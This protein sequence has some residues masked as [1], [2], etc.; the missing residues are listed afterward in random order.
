[1]RRGILAA[2]LFGQL[3]IVAAV[4][5]GATLGAIGCLSSNSS[6]PGPGPTPNLD[7]GGTTLPPPVSDAS[8]S[9]TPTPDAAQPVNDDAG[10]PSDDAGPP[11]F[12]AGPP[13]ATPPTTSQVGL[14]G[15][16]TLSRSAHYALVGSTGPATAPV[17]KS[18]RYQLTGGMA[19]ST[20]K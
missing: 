4:S 8:G 19:A 12:D 5:L 20:Q 7:A 16:G 17:L 15:G 2:P 3:A 9:V 11:P 6:T 10:E 1:M 14:V 13:D 18:S